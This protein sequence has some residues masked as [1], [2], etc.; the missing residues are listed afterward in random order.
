MHNIILRIEKLI[1]YSVYCV[2]RIN[3]LMKSLNH[4]PY[5]IKVMCLQNKL[6]IWDDRISKCTIFPLQHSTSNMFLVSSGM[7]DVKFV[8]AHQ[9]E[10]DRT[11]HT[12]KCMFVCRRK[13]AHSQCTHYQMKQLLYRAFSRI[14]EKQCVYIFSSQ[15]PVLKLH[16]VNCT[17]SYVLIMQVILSKKI[18][19]S[20]ILNPINHDHTFEL[21]KNMPSPDNLY[22][23]SHIQ[24]H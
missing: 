8:D 14:T 17:Q 21:M 22:S 16:S 24:M 4:H 2:H 13:T 20:P 15:V 9:V 23:I 19:D 1:N 18:L 12:L 11:F 6:I 5:H 3:S 10:Q 7:V